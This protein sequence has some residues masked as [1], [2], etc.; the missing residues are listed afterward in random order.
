MRSSHIFEVLSRAEA[1]FRLR[2][3]QQI[4]TGSEK[5]TIKMD[6]IPSASSIPE[7]ADGIVG[8]TLSEKSKSSSFFFLFLDY[9]P[10]LLSMYIALF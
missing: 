4:F 9:L 6:F 3:Q 5:E 2:G 7:E 10:G 8:K 1:A